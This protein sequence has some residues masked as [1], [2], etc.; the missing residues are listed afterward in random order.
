MDLICEAEEPDER[1]GLVSILS[2]LNQS[3]GNEAKNWKIKADCLQLGEGKDPHACP[4]KEQNIYFYPPNTQAI[5]WKVMNHK[6]SFIS[7]I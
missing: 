3:L 2:A 7:N 6:S 4:K 1:A 5:Y